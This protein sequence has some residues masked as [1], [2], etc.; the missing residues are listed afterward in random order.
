MSSREMAEQV[1]ENALPPESSRAAKQEPFIGNALV[2][3]VRT[4]STEVGVIWPRER[5]RSWASN[6]VVIVQ[7]AD[8]E[9]KGKL[10]EIPD[11]RKSRQ[12]VVEFP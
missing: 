6:L 2:V 12:V 7:Y 1:C 5:S 11:P 9:R 4:S 10:V 3:E 8:G